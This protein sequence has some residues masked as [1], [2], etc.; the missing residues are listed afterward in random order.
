[1]PIASATAR[2]SADRSTSSGRICEMPSESANF[3]A[4]LRSESCDD[5]TIALAR[6][7]AEVR[8]KCRS[9]PKP[10]TRGRDNSVM[11]RRGGPARSRWSTALWPSRSRTTSVQK[12]SARLRTADARAVF[13]ITIKMYSGDRLD[14]PVPL[15]FAIVL[16]DFA[17]FDMTY[18]DIIVI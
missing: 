5:T 11:S 16:E 8:R 12:S 10:S 9:T 3:I 4:A 15:D 7:P 13:T 1:M 14:A 18:G 6:A 2:F 17:S